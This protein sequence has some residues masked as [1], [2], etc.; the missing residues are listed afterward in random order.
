MSGG[1]SST[2]TTQIPQFLQNE[3]IANYAVANS[4]ASNPKISQTD[5]YLQAAALTPQQQQSFNAVQNMQ[6][7]P[8]SELAPAMQTATNVSNYQVQ[9]PANNISSYM[10][11]YINSVVN[12]SVQLLNQQRQNTDNQI[13]GQSASSG[14]FGGSQSQLRQGVNDAQSALL[15]GQLQGQ[16]SNQ[17]FSTAL[18]GAQNQA[19]LGLQGQYANLQGG[20]S[21]GNLTSLNTGLGLQTINAENQAGAQQQQ[22]AQNVLGYQNQSYLS[23]LN[24]GLQYGLNPLE[25]AVSSTPYGSSTSQTTSG[26]P[27]ESILGLGAL[28]LG[29]L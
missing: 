28:G 16:L 9:N 29:L 6:G 24:F 23:P 14:S 22:Q 1:G 10:N 3:A 13:A 25:S 15:A 11:P 18:Q 8:S 7:V 2:S 26:N 20:N 12:P 5:P 17:G 19:Q 4:I 27:L 21:L